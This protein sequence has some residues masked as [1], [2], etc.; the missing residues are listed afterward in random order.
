M[1][2]MTHR[3]PRRPYHP[4]DHEP[5]RLRQLLAGWEEIDP[6]VRGMTVAAVLDKLGA[7]RRNC[8]G[9][10]GEIWSPRRLPI[11]PL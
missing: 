7:Y 2:V 10:I 9:L 6:E 3:G 4:P 5:Q 11:V 1:P 8:V